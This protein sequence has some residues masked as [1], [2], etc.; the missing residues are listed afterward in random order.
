MSKAHILETQAGDT[1]GGG[2]PV[3]CS[4]YPII[5]SEQLVLMGFRVAK[6]VCL[7]VTMGHK[8]WHK[9]IR[10][11]NVSLL[12]IL[13]KKLSFPATTFSPGKCTLLGLQPILPPFVFT[14]SLAAHSNG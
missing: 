14:N 8:K 7:V 3:A 12:S 5:A 6:A 9:Y 1:V 4:T 11:N 13:R 10:G 2:M